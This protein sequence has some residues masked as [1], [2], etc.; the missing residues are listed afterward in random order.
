MDD[1]EFLTDREVAE[2]LRLNPSTLRAWRHFGRG[3]RWFKAG[4]VLYKRGDV[5]AWIQ[6]QY[7][8]AS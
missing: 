3:P 7:Q 2:R 5:E 1:Q 6:V 8:K 4:R